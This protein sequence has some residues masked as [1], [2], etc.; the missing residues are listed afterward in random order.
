MTFTINRRGT[1]FC[2]ALACLSILCSPA[3]ANDHLTIAAELGITP[4]S[5]VVAGV[6]PAAAGTVLANIEAE[7]EL[8]AQIAQLK[9]AANTAT[10][11]AT[12]L[13]ESLTL[14]PEPGLE[15]QYQIAIATLQSIQEDIAQLRNDLF[16]AITENLS[17]P[18]LDAL[19][20]WRTNGERRT[21]PEFRAALRT[22]EQWR[23]IEESL[24]AEARALRLGMSVPQ[25]PAQL[26]ADVR[27]EQAVIAAENALTIGM[28]AMEAAFQGQ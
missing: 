11:S 17:Q 2:A 8:T 9:T 14:A 26:L 18:Q 22:D 15:E 5:M 7:T 23:A 10:Q 4:T 25:P 6:T 24:R 13:A 3:L 28:T 20:V 21:P 16:A 19:Q 1:G 27:S 12:S